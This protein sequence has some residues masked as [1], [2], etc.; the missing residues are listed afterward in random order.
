M[1]HHCHSSI[2][3]SYED[4]G[5]SSTQIGDRNILLTNG[6]MFFNASSYSGGEG[7]GNNYERSWQKIYSKRY[8]LFYHKKVFLIHKINFI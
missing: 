1:L 5:S 3:T 7:N 6:V 8:D 2:K 4:I